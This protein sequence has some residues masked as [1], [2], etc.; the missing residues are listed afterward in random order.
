MAGLEAEEYGKL[1][2][3]FGRL[4]EDGRWTLSTTPGV[5]K[6]GGFIAGGEM[7]GSELMVDAMDVIG[8]VWRLFERR[9]N[10]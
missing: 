1:Q 6:Y 8:D 9:Y 3:P 10:G 7:A 5:G 2:D 4:S